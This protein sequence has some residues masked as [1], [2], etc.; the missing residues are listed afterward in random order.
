MNKLVDS[1]V[2]V[3]VCRL[4]YLCYNL[5]AVCFLLTSTSQVTGWEDHL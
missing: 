1:C 5:V 3:C 2:C 4:A